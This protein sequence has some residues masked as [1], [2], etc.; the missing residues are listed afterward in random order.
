MQGTVKHYMDMVSTVY[1]GNTS[2]LAHALSTI[3]ITISTIHKGEYP[4]TNDKKKHRGANNCTVTTTVQDATTTINLNTILN[5]VL[6][7][8]LRI[9]DRPLSDVNR[10]QSKKVY[11]VYTVSQCATKSVENWSKIFNLAEKVALG[12]LMY[13]SAQVQY[14]THCIFKK[15]LLLPAIR[16]VVGFVGTYSERVCSLTIS[17]G[18]K[19]L[20]SS[21]KWQPSFSGLCASGTM[22]SIIIDTV[23]SSIHLKPQKTSSSVSLKLW[24]S[25]VLEILPDIIV[26]FGKIWVL[27]KNNKHL[28]I[29][30][31]HY[32]SYLLLLAVEEF[33]KI[34]GVN[35][36]LMLPK[37]QRIKV[38]QAILHLQE[39]HGLESV[40]LNLAK[41]FMRQPV[42]I[43]VAV[44]VWLPGTM[45]VTNPQ[46]GKYV[47]FSL[48]NKTT[49]KEFYMMLRQWG[50]KH[51]YKQLQEPFMI[52]FNG[53]DVLADKCTT[54]AHLKRESTFLHKVAVRVVV[55]CPNKYPL[56]NNN[57]EELNNFV[58]SVTFMLHNSRKLSKQ[59]HVS[60]QKY[61]DVSRQGLC[62]AIR[63][64]RLQC[65]YKD[66][67]NR[68][69]KMIIDVQ[70]IITQI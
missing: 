33:E 12:L 17:L 14:D 10:L 57:T 38:Q 56:E 68:Y 11:A 49:S 32:L 45:C 53:Q 31:V 39:E 40:T 36:Q 50:M 24:F 4:L 70:S 34:H 18:L 19:V 2:D 41:V 55:I 5:T 47:W 16:A 25:S 7:V 15:K 63:H 42:T 22:A 8:I 48:S 52:Q 30:N 37:S 29:Q 60:T 62:L 61:K 58:E 66:L 35:K 67:E 26:R 64:H 59:L 65:K 9:F 20:N 43:M 44:E 69:N 27:E 46:N 1:N 3:Q 51:G 54:L 23:K 28:K 21:Q 6:Y 13:A